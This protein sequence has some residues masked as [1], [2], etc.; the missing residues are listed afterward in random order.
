MSG[1]ENLRSSGLSFSAL[2]QD[3]F[4]LCPA[5]LPRNPTPCV[6]PFRRF[7][8]VSQCFQNL[9]LVFDPV[10]C[11]HLVSGLGLLTSLPECSLSPY[12]PRSL[13][14][15][16]LGNRVPRFICWHVLVLL[17]LR[18]WMRSL[19]LPPAGCPQQ[20][21]GLSPSCL[22]HS[23]ILAVTILVQN[24]CLQFFFFY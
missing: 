5:R 24:S 3:T 12:S 17:Q 20:G 8:L 4:V 2:E 14:S 13:L 1:Y 21:L 10:Q 19:A 23:W 11:H 15:L 6:S 16:T 18:Q 22:S 9:P 7:S